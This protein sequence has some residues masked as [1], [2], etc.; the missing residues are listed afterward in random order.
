[1]FPSKQQQRKKK[2]EPLGRVS[3]QDLI[4]LV[5]LLAKSGVVLEEMEQLGVVHLQQHAGQLAG[6]LR[7][8]LSNQGVQLI[9]K[10]LLLPLGL[11]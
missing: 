3:K 5:E 6:R 9:A 1:L 2:C 4:G 8:A 10:N 11:R 7:V